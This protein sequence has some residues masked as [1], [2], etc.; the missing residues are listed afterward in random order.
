VLTLSS[1]QNAEKTDKKYRNCK[2]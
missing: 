2:Q 1:Q